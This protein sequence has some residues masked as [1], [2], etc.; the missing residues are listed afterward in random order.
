MPPYLVLL[1]TGFTLPLA[2]PQARCAL[3]APFHPYPT[4]T[5]RAGR[6]IFCGTGRRLAPPRRYLASCPLEPGLSSIPGN[7]GTAAAWPT[8]EPSLGKSGAFGYCRECSGGAIGCRRGGL[9]ALGS[10]PRGT[11]PE[12]IEGPRLLWFNPRVFARTHPPL[13]ALRT[14]EF[15]LQVDPRCDECR[16]NGVRSKRFS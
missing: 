14:A 2:L 5:R 12:F 3:T 9:T 1:R 8:P 11:R 4:G 15:L 7:P 13:P 10:T 16:F 6:Y